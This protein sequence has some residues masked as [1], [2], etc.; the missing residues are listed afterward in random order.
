MERVLSLLDLIGEAEYSTMLKMVKKEL[1]AKFSGIKKAPSRKASLHSLKGMCYGL[2]L[3]PLGKH[4]ALIEQTL[5]NGGERTAE[6]HLNALPA[7]VLLEISE[8]EQFLKTY[9]SAS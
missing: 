5:I 6:V 1:P 3:D 4:I 2:G 9:K 7:K 8:L